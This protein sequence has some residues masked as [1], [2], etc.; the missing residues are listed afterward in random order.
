[1]TVRD[2]GPGFDYEKVISG[3]AE[4]DAIAAIREREKYGPGLGLR[5]ILD[6]VDRIQFDAAGQGCAIHMAKY[7]DEDAGML[8]I[9]D[10]EP[11]DEHEAG[12]G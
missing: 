4:I 11:S 3:A 12:E 10:E 8:V 7:K 6:C 5:M 2:L 9:E 1:M